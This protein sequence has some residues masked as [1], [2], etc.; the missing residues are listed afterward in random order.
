MA[1]EC[2]CVCYNTTAVSASSTVA[3]RVATVSASLMGLAPSACGEHMADSEQLTRVRVA[4]RRRRR[5]R[6]S[7]ASRDSKHDVT[8][9]PV[10]KHSQIWRCRLDSRRLS[11]RGCDRSKSRMADGPPT[12]QGLPEE[13]SPMTQCQNAGPQSRLLASTHS[14]NRLPCAH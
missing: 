6:N 14:W 2:V 11:S 1:A 5:K 12:N 10:R 8:A 13:D 9:N 3:R 7:A 4:R